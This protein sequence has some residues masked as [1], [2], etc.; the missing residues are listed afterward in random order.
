MAR[1]SSKKLSPFDGVEVQKDTGKK[2]GFGDLFKK[3]FYL[4]SRSCIFMTGYSLTLAALVA[5]FGKMYIPILLA[6]GVVVVW[7]FTMRFAENC[8]TIPF[9][10]FLNTALIAG[11]Y[12]LPKVSPDPMSFYCYVPLLIGLTALSS[13]IRD[14]RAYFT[15]CSVAEEVFMPG[16]IAS[17][18]MLTAAVISKFAFEQ[19]SIGVMLIIS[20]AINGLIAIFLSKATGKKV[21]MT[22]SQLCDV[23]DYHPVN[24]EENAR[25]LKGR[26]VFAG[27]TIAVLAGMIALN[28]CNLKFALN[29]PFG[30]YPIA[31][32]LV[33]VI[34][35][36][37]SRR[38]FDD[39]FAIESLLIVAVLPV[40]PSL[41]GV[42]VTI[43]G[44][45]VVTGFLHTYK[46]RK[47]FTEINT[48]FDGLPM[49]T[50]VLGIAIMLIEAFT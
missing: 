15:R 46:R 30:L 22:S 5:A 31:A 26:V 23:H 7:T 47:L 45:I 8:R 4:S 40:M 34:F 50:A 13:S 16:V 36:L 33:V 14:G 43:A 20:S 38:R 17:F 44:D 1:Y 10:V 29:L 28:I 25:F 6:L 18:S 32:A 19:K 3:N 39:L 11:L 37:I 48:Y 2:Q 27:E 21:R 49:L 12:F 41:I 9:N 24:V 35:I 42:L